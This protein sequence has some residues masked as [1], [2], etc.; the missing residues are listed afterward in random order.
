MFFFSSKNL[1][2]WSAVYPLGPDDSGTFLGA[3]GG[4]GAFTVVK[5]PDLG[6]GLF[7]R[8]FFEGLTTF[9]EV[10]LAGL[11]LAAFLSSLFWRLANNFATFLTLAGEALV[12][13]TDLEG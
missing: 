1:L 4:F 5:G 2:Y 11:A 3:F 10:F 6:F 8:T 13:L 7:A 9:E 12:N